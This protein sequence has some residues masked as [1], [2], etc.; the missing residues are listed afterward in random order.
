MKYLN[1]T[2]KELMNKA[3]TLKNDYIN[4]KPFPHIV[5]DNFFNE[6]SLSLLIENFPKN[7]GEYNAQFNNKNEKKLSLNNPNQFSDE[8]NNF[9]NF[10]N[11]FIFTNFLQIITNINEALIPDP[12][13]VGGG[14]HELKNNGYLNI[15]ADFN[16]HPKIKLDRRLN[17]LIYLNKNWSNENG[18]QLELWNKEMTKCCQSILPKFNRMV[19]FSTTTF[20]YHGNPNKVKCLENT[21]RKSLALYYYSNGRPLNEIKLGNHSTIFRKRPGTN[22][23]DGN[24]KFKRLFGKFYLRTKN[25]K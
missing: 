21:S 14:L 22:D 15:H 20:S 4:A 17:V 23:I 12:Y 9:I 13:L 8:S 25:N 5:L 3:I 1:F 19:I 18:G 16:T 2:T 11:S 10:L 6:E 24:I 7:T